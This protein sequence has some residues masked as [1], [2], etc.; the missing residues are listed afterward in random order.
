MI[1]NINL[2]KKI[3][4]IN[5]RLFKPDEKIKYINDRLFKPDEKNQIYQ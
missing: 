2:M 3:K 1:D 5:D 4:Y